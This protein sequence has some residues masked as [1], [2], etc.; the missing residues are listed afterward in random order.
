M[1]VYLEE[2]TKADDPLLQLPNVVAT[3][4]M[5]GSTYDVYFRAIGN[6]MENFRR[7]L[8]GEP[9]QWVVNEPRR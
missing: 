4:H 5:A 7:V 3:P 8:R 2:P 1:D 6:A 9:A